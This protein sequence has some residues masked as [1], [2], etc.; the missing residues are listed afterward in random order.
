[1]ALEGFPKFSHEPYYLD[2]TRENLTVRSHVPPLRRH[3]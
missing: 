2:Y 1:M 3:A